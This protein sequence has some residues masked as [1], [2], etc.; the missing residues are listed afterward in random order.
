MTLMD[1]KYVCRVLDVLYI[2]TV[3]LY[4]EWE[5][6]MNFRVDSNQAFLLLSFILFLVPA[7]P[8][9]A[10]CSQT[11]HIYIQIFWNIMHCIL[12]NCLQI[13]RRNMCAE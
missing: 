4:F 10:L 1:A 13:F 7:V 6:M 3:F 8:S 11:N 12:V 2:K 9:S 5:I